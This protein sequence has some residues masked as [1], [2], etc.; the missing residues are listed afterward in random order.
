MN[1]FK[2]LKLGEPGLRSFVI[3]EDGTFNIHNIAQGISDI[4]FHSGNM[5]AT[6]KDLLPQYEKGKQIILIGTNGYSQN[7]DRQN[8]AAF[9]LGFVGNNDFAYKITT[10]VSIMPHASFVT[11]KGE[12]PAELQS[13]PMGFHALILSIMKANGYDCIPAQN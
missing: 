9:T 1:L 8:V 3:N 13:E 5:N 4:A 7:N 12:T 11:Q 10:G 2:L 6:I